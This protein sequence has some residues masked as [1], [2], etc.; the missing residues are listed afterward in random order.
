MILIGCDVHPSWQEVC[1]LDR[2]TL[3]TVS[4]ASAD[5]HGV[6]WELSVVRG[7]GHGTRTRSVDWRCSEDPRQRRAPA[8]ARQAGRGAAV[9]DGRKVS[10]DLD[11]LERA[12]GSPAVAGSSLQAGAAAGASKERVATSGD[13]PGGAEEKALI[14]PDEGKPS[15]PVL[16][17]L[18]ASNGAR[19]LGH[20]Q[21]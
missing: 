21:H 17:G 7:D 8:E 12:E 9:A 10:A 18:G 5:R 6:H 15:S 20:M 14:E 13:E 2:I 19:P 4:G 1:W 11:A 3:P 16:R